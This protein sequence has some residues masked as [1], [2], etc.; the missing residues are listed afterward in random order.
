MGRQGYQEHSFEGLL[1]RQAW[2]AETGS[3]DIRGYIMRKKFHP[4]A[5]GGLVG[6]VCLTALQYQAALAQVSEPTLASFEIESQPLAKA[7]MKYSEQSRV[8]IV[9][10]S[11]LVKG[12]T[13]SAVGGYLEPSMALDQLLKGTGSGTPDSSVT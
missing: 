2:T 11:N 7:L 8:V 5:K 10:P 1:L 3:D 9:A 13:S 6:A 4:I 12:K